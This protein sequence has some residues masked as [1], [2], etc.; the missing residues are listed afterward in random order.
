MF[1]LW[2]NFIGCVVTLTLGWAISTLRHEAAD[3]PP[4]L[5]E[6]V[7]HWHARET[8]LLLG[9]FAGMLVIG[10]ADTGHFWHALTGGGSERTLLAFG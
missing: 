3:T 5:D 9:A 8:W 7:G 2:W 1:W 4:G 6:G 10:S